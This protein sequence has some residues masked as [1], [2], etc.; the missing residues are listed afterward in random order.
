MRTGIIQAIATPVITSGS[1]YA[2]GNAL[3]STLTFKGLL[4]GG[5][6]KLLS[7]VILDK[8]NQKAAIDLILFNQLLSSP[9]TDKTALAISSADLLN[10]NGRLSFAAAGYTSLSAS[11]NAENT[12]S[13]I[14]L[15]MTSNQ[16]NNLY[17]QLVCRG[18]P[19][20]VS[21]SDLS[22]ILTV[23]YARDA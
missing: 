2:S 10:L 15:G 8:S 16:D 14:Q 6:S 20:Y 9:Q 4:D 17:G 13:N 22:V 11:S 23:E 1:A 5:F 18:T 19:T 12:L 3:G 21:T 7:A